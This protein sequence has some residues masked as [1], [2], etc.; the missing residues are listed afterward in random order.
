MFHWN[1]A[2]QIY[3][4]RS[5]SSDRTPDHACLYCLALAPALAV[6]WQM[7]ATPNDL[8]SK[9]TWMNLEKWEVHPVTAGRFFKASCY[10]CEWHLMTLGDVPT[11]QPLPLTLA[12]S[13]V[14]SGS[15]CF[16]FSCR[17]PEVLRGFSVSTCLCKLFPS[18]SWNSLLDDD[19]ISSHIMSREM[20]IIYGATSLSYPASALATSA[21]ASSSEVQTSL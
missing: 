2:D 21:W 6:P 9:R 15:L 1:L 4:G 8:G 14:C 20:W 10:L 5:Q 7:P 16:S 17:A 19:V 12:V 13:A 3:V 18:P 11:R